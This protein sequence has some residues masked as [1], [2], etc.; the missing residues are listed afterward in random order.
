MHLKNHTYDKKYLV[1]QTAS[2]GD[3]ILSTAIGEKLI[4][5]YPN[6]QI[7]YLVKRGNERLFDG[8]PWINEIVVWD[9]SNDKYKNMLRI[10]FQFRDEKY[11]A[12]INLQ[13]FFSSGIFTMFSGAKKTF[14]FRK[15]PLS[16]FFSRA[17]PHK[18]KNN[19]HETDRN[20][21]LIVK[22]T[23]I[24]KAKPS[25]YPTMKDFAIMSQYK[26]QKYITIT[27][28]SI[29]FTKQYP[30]EKWIDFI[31]NINPKTNIYLLGST[32]DKKL[33]DELIKQTDR[34][35]MMNLAGKLSFMES[36][37]LMRDAWMN[38]VNDSAAQ[39]IASA[40]NGKITAIFCSTVPSF[41]FG[42]LSD[43]SVII[44]NKEKLECRPCGL[45]G[46][47]NCPEKHFK[48]ALDIDTKELLDRL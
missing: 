2:I 26:T 10:I 36:A 25:L 1:I 13:R 47:K 42:P 14:G 8:N 3:V 35:Y 34:D 6:A 27:P 16:L 39:H 32:A 18:F 43:N 28:A 29:W 15:N 48:C 40:V 12:V 5:Q 20:H 33:C 11:D 24:E 45:H 31:Q 4:Q 19:W 44:E 7:D 30:I 46:H 41:G 37:A 21:Q 22:L 17:F 9:K 38:F 23:D